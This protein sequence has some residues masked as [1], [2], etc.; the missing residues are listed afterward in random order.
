ML[1]PHATVDPEAEKSTTSFE[2][3]IENQE[4]EVVPKVHSSSSPVP[5]S[6]HE[7]QK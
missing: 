5:K 1:R 2:D 6:C 3:A 7:G 4:A